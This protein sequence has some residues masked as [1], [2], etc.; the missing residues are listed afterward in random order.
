[1]L[2][3]HVRVA[4]AVF[5]LAFLS[6]SELT[7]RWFLMFMSMFVSFSVFVVSGE[8]IIG[9]REATAHSRPYMASIQVPEGETMKHEC[10]GFVVADQWVM[11]A[12]HCLPT[13]CEAPLLNKC[14]SNETF[15]LNQ[16][17]CSSSFSSVRFVF[18]TE[19]TEGRPG[20]PFSEP[21]RGHQAD[22]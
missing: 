21:T 3:K 6:H 19:R 2:E 8:G 13:G 20:G 14:C 22:I 12:V 18:Q 16:P 17:C 9:G 1:M 10:G 5:I 15:L 11:T 7:C 4:A